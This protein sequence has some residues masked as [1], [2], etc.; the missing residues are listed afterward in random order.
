LRK[1]SPR[2]CL[3]LSHE[4]IGVLQESFFECLAI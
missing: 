4:K 1:L 2:L 3:E